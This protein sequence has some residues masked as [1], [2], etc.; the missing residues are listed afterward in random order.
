MTCTHGWGDRGRPLLA[1]LPHGHWKTLTFIAGLRHDGIV[2]P[3]VIDSPINS[4]SFAAWVEQFLIPELEP[5]SILILDNLGS[6]KTN[7]VR[8]LPRAAGIKPFSLPP[9]SP[10]LNPIKQVFSKRKR[11]LRK[12]NEQTVHATWHRSGSLP[13]GFSPA[14]C[15]NYTHNNGHA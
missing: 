2:A 13:D 14:E 3:G 5:G 15:P 6:H 1:K 9:Y 7:R 8:K 10:H 11:L 12:A 4:D